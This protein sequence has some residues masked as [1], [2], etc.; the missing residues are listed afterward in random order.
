MR[1]LQKFRIPTVLTGLWV[2]AALVAGPPRYQ[3]G[4]NLLRPPSRGPIRAQLPCNTTLQAC[5]NGSAAGDTIN[6]AAGTYTIPEL[7]IPLALNLNGAGVNNTFLQPDGAHR[8]VLISGGIA[9]GVTLSNLTIQKG[10]GA[11]NG[12][13]LNAGA[14]T[15]LT[16]NRVQVRDNTSTSSGGGIF[17]WAR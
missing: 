2:A 11:A 14:G 3:H 9:A 6:I 4:P 8:V 5:V 7:T 16:L 15:P 10:S 13:G 1:D 12:A 17:V